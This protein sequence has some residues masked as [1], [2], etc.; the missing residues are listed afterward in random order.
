M[1]PDQT[2]TDQPYA[3]PDV[4]GDAY[5]DNGQSAVYSQDVLID[6]NVLMEHYAG[7][8]FRG[9]SPASSAKSTDETHCEADP[10]DVTTGRMILT[11]TDATLPGLPLIRTYRSDYRWGRS[12]GPAWASPLDQRIIVDSEQVR[13]LAS[14][15]SILTYPLVAEG[16]TALPTLGRAL[17]LRRLVGGGWLLTDPAS[18]QAWVF[19]PASRGESLLSDVTDGGLRW[20]ITRDDD[21]TVTALRSSAGAT[22]EFTSSEGLVTAVRL[23]EHDG[24]L[25]E[26]ARFGYDQDRQLVEVV[27]SSGDP[28]RFR[29]AD[30]RIVRWDDRN[31]EWYTY[32]YDEAGRCVGTDGRDGFLRYRFEYSDGLTVVTDSLGAVRRY[33]LNDRLQ[34]VTE[35]DALGATTRNEWDDAYRLLSRTDPLGRTTR[36]EY[37]AD[38]RPTVVTRPDGSSSTTT[39]DELGRA[40]SWT[41][42]DGSTG[43]R[44]F[45]TD[46]R[47]L[48]EIDASGEV[49]RFD[50][51]VEGGRGTAIQ[52][53]P[54]VVV[55][56]AVRQITSITTGEGDTRY[57]YD[58]LGRIVKIETDQGITNVGWTL[59]GD[60]A[61]RENPDGVIEEFG[62]D[63]EGNL[64]ETL[65]ATGRRTYLEYG[66]FDLVTARIDDEDNRT[67]YAYDTELR[68]TG[69]TDPQG[70]T[71]QYTYD[72]NGRLVEETDFDGRTQRYAYDAAGQL[73]EHTDAAGEVTHFSYDVLGR[74]VERR[75]GTAVT[76]LTYDP[77]G[78]IVAADDADSQIRLERDALGRVVAETVNGQTVSSAY[79]D[80]SEAVTAR[81]RPSGAVT[82][83]SYDES[84]RP[85]L[86]VAGGQRLRFA[87]EDGREVGRAWEAGLTIDQPA[88]PTAAPDEQ[89]GEPGDVRYTLD[90]LGRPAT[91]SGEAGDWHLTWDHRDRLATVTTPDG[92]RWQYRYDAFGRRIAKQRHGK[93]GAVLEETQFVWSGDLLVE[94]H[95]RDGTGRV[96]TT[97]WEYHPAL[98]YPVAQVTDGTVHAVVT[99]DAGTPPEL[100]GTDG[101]RP[102][103]PAATPL[104]LGGRY[105]DAETG[106][107][108]DG[109]RY[110]DPATARFLSGSRTAPAPLG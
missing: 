28:E 19:A 96:T 89:T 47:V 110:Y 70:R 46:G 75:T 40:T 49:V 82:R 76:R 30:G 81:T 26:A 88:N 31:G 41:D 80:Q 74:V 64:V 104:R 101:S 42:F 100:V 38:G 87:Y 97:A 60:L 18:G 91:R 109:S 62:Y 57:E 92:D 29:Y 39:Y 7:P 71:W 9:A 51:P 93:D 56:N 73:V 99:G 11:E 54:E 98:A 17:P 32:T 1:Y 16:A 79:R 85:A 3:D 6:P 58:R 27:N 86:L 59:E 44:E 23:P 43:S 84:G 50:R 4:P 95:H 68:L 102:D 21:G 15:G 105:L 67:E 90:A 83:W 72:P 37:D 48:A 25:V 12:F 13:Y 55:R 22:I 107:Q 65:D 20:A 45:D 34:V 94:Q 52:V 35:T 53:G 8:S 69:I 77:A 10:I 36:Y 33:E 63:G 61:W 2:Y 108:Y 14:D 78:R 103:E 66:A 24:T 106:L 5:Y